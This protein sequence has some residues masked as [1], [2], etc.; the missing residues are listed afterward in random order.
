MNSFR[1][2]LFVTLLSLCFCPIFASGGTTVIVRGEPLERPNIVLIIPDDMGYADVEDF[3]ADKEILTPNIDRLAAEGVRLTDA[4]V[5]APICMPSRAALINGR[6]QVG[7]GVYNNWN[8]SPVSLSQPSIAKLLKG[9]GYRTCLLGKWHLTGNDFENWNEPGHPDPEEL[10]FD[11]VSIIYGGMITDFWNAPLHS[12]EEYPDELVDYYATDYFSDK[13]VEFIADVTSTSEKPF[14]LH[15]AYN[16]V[17]APLHAEEEDIEAYAGMG[18]H[19]DRQIYAGMMRSMDRGIGRVLDALEQAGVADNTLIFFVNDNGGPALDAQWHSYNR[20]DNDPLRGHK[21]GC[22]DGGIR[23]PMIISWPDGLPQG[24]NH[25]GLIS[26]MD[27]LPTFMAAANVSLPEG[28]SFDGVNLLPYLRGE[29]SGSPHECLHWITADDNWSSNSAHAATRQGKW[30][31]WQHCYIKDG[32]PDA[33]SWELYDL[34]ADPGE[35]T[36]LAAQ[37]PEKV[38]ELNA[39]WRTWYTEMLERQ[40]HWKNAP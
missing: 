7:W 38:A 31:I 22:Y 15:L 30:K 24:Q 3:G 23:V 29:Q 21:F 11:Q 37:H 8:F 10:G 17:H 13:A 36:N 20:A 26:A 9:A 16:A 14:F 19:K 32:G 28:E 33:T 2:H 18:L 12:T 1:Y 35:S 25:G 5:T 34:A 4:Y 39:A 40:E 27:I 6:H